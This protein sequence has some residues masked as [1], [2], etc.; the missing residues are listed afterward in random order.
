MLNKKIFG[1]FSAVL[2][3]GALASQSEPTCGEKIKVSHCANASSQFTGEESACS[4]YFTILDDKGN[5]V[6]YPCKTAANNKCV[7]DKESPC[8]L[9]KF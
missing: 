4:D 7:T 1:L 9:K 3:L 5:E 2:F 8:P 6:A